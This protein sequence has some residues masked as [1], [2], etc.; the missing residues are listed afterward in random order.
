VKNF[1]LI[2]LVAA[3][4][5]KSAGSMHHDKSARDNQPPVYRTGCAQLPR[6]QGGPAPLNYTPTCGEPVRRIGFPPK[7]NPVSFGPCLLL[8]KCFLLNPEK[9]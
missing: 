6:Y 5:F 1:N 2:S 3:A 7:D 8:N 4:F 9:N